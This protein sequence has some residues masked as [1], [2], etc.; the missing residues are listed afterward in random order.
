MYLP[1]SHLDG[2]STLGW[3][4]GPLLHVKL[5]LKLSIIKLNECS[6]AVKKAFDSGKRHFNENIVK[7]NTRYIY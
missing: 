7:L 3:T 4:V 2:A 6:N 5:S 1:R